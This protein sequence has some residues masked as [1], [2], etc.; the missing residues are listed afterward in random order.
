M[1]FQLSHVIR[2]LTCN[3]SRFGRLNLRLKIDAYDR[4]EGGESS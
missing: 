4:G 2:V 1:L 3:A